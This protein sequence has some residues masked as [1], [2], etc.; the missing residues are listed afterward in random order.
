MYALLGTDRPVESYRTEVAPDLSAKQLHALAVDAGVEVGD[1]PGAELLR[2]RLESVTRKRDIDGTRTVTVRF[3]DGMPLMECAQTVTIPKGVWDSHSPG[4]FEDSG[5]PLWVE[6]NSPT[7]QALLAEHYGC[8][9]GAPKSAAAQVAA[10]LGLPVLVAM[11]LVML[12]SPRLRVAAGRDFQARVMGDSAS[13]GTGLYASA[14]FLAVTEN[15]TAPADADT[16]LLGELTVGG[17]ARA[18]ATYARTAGTTTYTLSLT[19]T[20]ADATT[21]TLQ[22]IGIFNA[23][24]AGTLVFE[25]AIPSPPALVSGD[26]AALTSTIT[27]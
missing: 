23:G 17:F 11:L 19:L 7:L 20:S 27:I 22:K 18:A 6:S 25:T 5:K 3:P 21:R 8:A 4:G 16:A 2:A 15:S 26:Q 10:A 9:S 24:T 14:R 12:L 13:T 1:R